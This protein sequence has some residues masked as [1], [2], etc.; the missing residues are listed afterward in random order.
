MDQNQKPG[1]LQIPG[2]LPVMED[3][4]P[5]FFKKDSDRGCLLIH[6]FTGTTSSMRPMGEYLASRGV[7]VLSPR[8]PGHGTTP[9][10]MS[11]T[12]FEDW[13]QSAEKAFLELE[14]LCDRVF[15][16]GLSMGGTLT[17]RL[18]EK[19]P[20]RIAGIIP[21]STLVFFKNPVVKLL[22]V[23]KLFIKNW[24]GIG[25]DLKDPEATEIAYE[26]FP[27]KALHELVK[28]MK[29]TR[30]DLPAI[31]C[32]VRIFQ[33]R[34]DHVVPPG[35]GP[36]IFDNVSSKNKELIWLDN[37]YHVATLD[38]DRESIFD[39]SYSFISG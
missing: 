23:M 6:G 36:Y 39:Q 17:L 16:G 15:V 32:P 38:L 27:L 30:D 12:S 28:L 35:N 14:Q 7:T 10:D 21:V 34:E 1:C 13:F 4:E 5:F 20:D 37:C 11:G 9:D 22:P 33:A 26:R 29:I 25:G 3:G 2:G 24:K 18:A 19:Y 31:T 8:L